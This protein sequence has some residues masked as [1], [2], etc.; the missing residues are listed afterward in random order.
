MFA[1]IIF[2]IIII[3]INTT[4][5]TIIII[6]STRLYPSCKQLTLDVGRDVYVVYR[7]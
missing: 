7:K 5:F 6:V 4:I 3:I 1:I 2:I